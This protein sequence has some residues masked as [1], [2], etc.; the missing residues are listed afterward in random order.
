MTSGRPPR[1]PGSSSSTLRQR[2][3]GRKTKTSKEGKTTLR[4]QETNGNKRNDKKNKTRGSSKQKKKNSYKWL[5]AAIVI[6]YLPMLVLVNPVTMSNLYYLLTRPECVGVCSVQDNDNNNNNNNSC[7]MNVNRL[8]FMRIPK[9][10]TSTTL[11]LLETASR[12]KSTHLIDLGE[13][14][15]YVSSIPLPTIF[16]QSN[17]RRQ[18]PPPPMGY[19]YP[20]T[21]RNRLRQFFRKASTKVL[22]PPYRNQDRTVYQGHFPY[23]DFAQQATLLASQ[24]SSM[25]R[26]LPS[27]LQ[28]L[29]GITPEETQHDDL[30]VP[31]M[32]LLRHPHQR[33]SSMYYY[34]RHS[35][36]SETWRKEYA[37]RFGN[38]TLNDCLLDPA[39]V[40]SNRLEDMCQ[41]QVNMVCGVSCATNS[42]EMTPDDRLTVAKQNLD[43]AFAYVGIANRMDESMKLLFDMFPTFLSDTVPTTW[44]QEKKQPHKETQFDPKAQQV[45]QDICRHD[46]ALYQH[47]NDI[48][49][50]RLHECFSSSSS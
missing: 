46:Q 24:P 3:T 6:L 49:T 48:L 27:W 20:S 36:R 21:F 41:L 37:K 30:V 38:A 42:T 18:P 25:L 13:M 43:N 34:D 15:E 2:P 31:T 40:Q 14:E 23:F 45:L 32:T 50:Q 22:Y 4:K 11:K 1:P 17:Q 9:T 16:S 33:L 47:A 26:S 5:T 7:A 8:V 44:P 29:Y 35:T 10:A 12:N 39:C 19:H 28:P